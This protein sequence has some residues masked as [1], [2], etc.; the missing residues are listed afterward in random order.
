MGEVTDP[1]SIE[2][3]YQL[4]NLEILHLDRYDPVPKSKLCPV[5]LVAAFMLEY[6]RLRSTDNPSPGK[7]WHG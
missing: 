5:V 6:S 1:A 4:E 2:V 7:D 3:E